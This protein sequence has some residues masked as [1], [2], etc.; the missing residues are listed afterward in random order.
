MFYFWN[1]WNTLIVP[2]RFTRTINYFLQFWSAVLHL[3]LLLTNYLFTFHSASFVTKIFLASVCSPGNNSPSADWCQ[4][5]LSLLTASRISISLIIQLPASSWLWNSGLIIA[6]QTLC[7]AL[8]KHTF[9][10]LMR[11][12]SILFFLS[13][14]WPLAIS[15]VT[16][17]SL[18][19]LFHN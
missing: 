14:L 17:P 16:I 18:K 10:S 12:V 15:P 9:F 11:F 2:P 7:F 3:F 5:R 8:S 4:S 19:S 1:L 13:S 6:L